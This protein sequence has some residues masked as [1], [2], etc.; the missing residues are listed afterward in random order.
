MGRAARPRPVLGRVAKEASALSSPRPSF[1]RTRESIPPIPRSAE[2][3]IVGAGVIGLSIAFELA[4]RG[5]APVV[6][7]RDRVGAGAASAAAGMLAPVS[8]AE[9]EEPAL[10]DLAVDSHRRYPEFVAAVE[11][12]SGISCGFRREGTLTV[13]LGRDHEA[14]LHHLREAQRSR[15]LTAVSLTADEVFAL[16]P[17]LSGWATAGLLAAEDYQVDPRLLLA[18][19]NAA[20]GAMGV[21]VI[22]GVRVTAVEPSSNG[23]RVLADAGGVDVEIECDAAVVAAGAWIDGLR[24]PAGAFGVRPVKGQVVRLRAPHLI[25]HV[26]RTPDVYVLQRESGELLIGAT[27]EDQGFDA[28]PTAG[29]VMDLLRSAWH[30]LPAVYDCELQE[31]SVS[32]RPTSR[33]HVPIIGETEAEGVF[34]ATG[35]YRHGVLLAPATAH[36]LSDMITAGVRSDLLARFDP[37]RTGAAAP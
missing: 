14:D 28:S 3:V 21:R 16:E 20:V 12:A 18:A 4:R 29:A 33:D 15:G 30:L 27:V 2:I 24:T 22:E 11:E 37:E 32:F 10:V 35:H 17:H 6:L 34:V 9:A 1:L 5:R 23:T 7:E 19:L 31:V 26:L 36:L 8:E 25:D 13:A